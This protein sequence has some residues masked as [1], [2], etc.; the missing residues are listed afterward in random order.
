MVWRGIIGN[1]YACLLGVATL[2]SSPLLFI[3]MVAD[4][5]LLHKSR[6]DTSFN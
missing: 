4:R 3:G 1:A 5:S 2:L 6:R